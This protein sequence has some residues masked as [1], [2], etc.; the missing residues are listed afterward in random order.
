MKFTYV[1]F[2]SSIF[3]FSCDNS[4]QPKGNAQQEK[5]A[6]PHSTN[7][8]K[9]VGVKD[10]D[11]IEVLVNG[12]QETVRLFAI[13]CPEKAQAYGQVAKKFTS[14]LCYGKYVS[15]EPQAQRDQ[16]DRI[17]GIVY[18]DDTLVLNE[19]LLKAGYAWHYKRYSNNEQYS[20]LE[21][22]ARAEHLGLWADN[23]PTPPWNWRHNN[24][25][26]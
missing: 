15:I 5:Q 3:L 2:I 25:R 19:A 16:Y 10:G 8:V 9:V 23:K 1:I 22:T 12:K 13:D 20:Y 11:T 7:K 6:V 17:V 14:S 18:I 26:N 4:A 21:N 24:K